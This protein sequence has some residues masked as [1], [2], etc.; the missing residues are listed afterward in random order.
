[1][2]KYHHFYWNSNHKQGQ[3]VGQHSSLQDQPWV[4]GQRHWFCETQDG[5]DGQNFGRDAGAQSQ[6]SA[7]QIAAVDPFD[8][9]FEVGNPK[10]K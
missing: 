3:V 6:I 2:V 9:Q 1:M 7:G 5:E 4:K 8:W 10:E